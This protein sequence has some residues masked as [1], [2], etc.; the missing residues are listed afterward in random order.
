MLDYVKRFFIH[1]FSC[2]S[3]KEAQAGRRY[4]PTGYTNKDGDFIYEDLETTYLFESDDNMNY[5]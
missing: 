3:E 2:F 4:N 1:L 5:R